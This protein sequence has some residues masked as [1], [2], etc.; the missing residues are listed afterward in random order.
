MSKQ[1]KRLTKCAKLT[2]MLIANDFVLCRNKKHLVFRQEETNK[3]FTIGKT[4]SC[5]RAKKNNVRNLKKLIADD[6]HII[7]CMQI[8]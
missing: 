3:K 8:H 6:T 1:I 5:H 7:E 4:V 2:E